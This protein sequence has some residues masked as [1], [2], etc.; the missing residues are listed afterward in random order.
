MMRYR[1]TIELFGKTATGLRVPP[2]VVASFG[3]GKRP[4]VLVTIGR[5]TYRSTVAAYGDEFF[6]PLSA[7]NRASVG[8][9][10]GDEVEV[11]LELDTQPRMIEVPPDLSAALDAA[12]DA[13]RHFDGLSYSHQR[14][15]VTWISDAKRVETRE[16]RIAKA[17]EML[18]EGR[19]Q[20]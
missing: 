1:A 20:R 5:H 14:Q 15:Y 6:L 4:P 19:T 17:V 8:V 3:G 13:R 7:K 12:A 11:D 2:E 9:E 10:A 18:R 16:R